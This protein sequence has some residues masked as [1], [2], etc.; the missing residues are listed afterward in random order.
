LL[1][2][3][4]RFGFDLPDTLAGH[5]E[6]VAHFFQRVAVAVAQ[7]IANAAPSDIA[8]GSGTTTG[9]KRIKATSASAP[10]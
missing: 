9:S 4:H 6:N 3:A 2:L 10:K 8:A 7:A 5:F 1:Q